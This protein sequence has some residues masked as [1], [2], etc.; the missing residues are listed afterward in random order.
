MRLF[1]YKRTHSGDPG[2]TGCFGIYNCMRSRRADDFEVV[3]GVGGEGRQA[4]SH[5]IAG[6]VNFIG[7]GPERHVVPVMRYPVITFE[8]FLDLSREDCDFRAEA[9]RL[10]ARM[11]GSSLH[12]VKHISQA[13]LIEIEKLLKRAKA[14]PRSSASIPSLRAQMA[15]H[16]KSW[17]GADFGPKCGKQRST[18]R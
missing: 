1:I 6:K 13:E 8:H 7:F 12:F 9:P 10:A 5:G 17:P 4:I 2:P 11:Y 15:K 14:A 3:I 18:R 16:G